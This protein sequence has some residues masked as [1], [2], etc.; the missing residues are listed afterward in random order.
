MGWLAIA[1]GLLMAFGLGA[2]WQGNA[3]VDGGLRVRAFDG[4]VPVLLLAPG[5]EARAEHAWYRRFALPRWLCPGDLY[6]THAEV[7]DGK[8]SFTLQLFHP[9]FGL[10]LRQMAMFREIAP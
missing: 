3:P 4:A 2:A 7:A 6:V 10:L 9:R 1:A 5:A 8:F